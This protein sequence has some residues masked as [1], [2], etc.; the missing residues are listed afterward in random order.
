MEIVIFLSIEVQ[1]KQLNS[2]EQLHTSFV[3]VVN[4]ICYCHDNTEDGASETK[5]FLSPKFLT[6]LTLVQALEFN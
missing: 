5:F 1:S 3:Y 6:I 4:G 2:S